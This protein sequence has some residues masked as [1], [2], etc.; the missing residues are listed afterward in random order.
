MQ[1][2]WQLRAVRATHHASPMRRARTGTSRAPDITTLPLHTLTH[3]HTH[4][5]ALPTQFGKIRFVD[6]KTPVR[7][8]AYGFVEFGESYQYSKMPGMLRGW[9]GV[10][11]MLVCMCACMQPRARMPT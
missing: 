3:T 9:A 1:G 6:I 5:N 2:Q 11:G 7:P 4:P 8:P 10:G